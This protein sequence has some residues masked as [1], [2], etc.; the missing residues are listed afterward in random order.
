[1]FLALKGMK[2]GYFKPFLS[3]CPGSLT[4]VIYL[5]FRFPGAAGMIIMWERRPLK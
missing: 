4:V 3:C 1:M 2:L 5:A